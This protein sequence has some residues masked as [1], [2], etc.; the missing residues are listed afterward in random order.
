MDF[1]FNPG[2]IA[3]L[4]ATAN[5]K[6]GG[7]SILKNLMTGFSGNIYPVNPRYTEINSLPCYENITQVPD[8]VDMA[9]I[10]VPATAAPE[11]V[12]GCA[13]RGIPGVIIQSAGFSETG[14]KGKALQNQLAGISRRTGIRIWGPNCMGL[15][16]AIHKK[17]FSFVSP[18][19]WDA[20]LLPGGI[21]LIVQSG[22]LSAGFLMDTMTRDKMGVSKV[23]SIGNKVDVNECDVLE[24]LLEDRDTAVIGL[25]LESIMD[26]RR[27]F[28]TCRDA[29]KPIV[30]LQ[31]GKSENGARA[32][33]SHTASMAGNSAII[34]GAMTQAGVV[35][36]DDFKQMMDLSHTLSLYPN[37][38]GRG[39]GRIAI[40]TFSG[41]AGIVSSDFLDRHGLALAALSTDTHQSL[42]AVFPQWMPPS[43]PIDLW[44]AIE[45]SG[46]DKAYGQ[47]VDAVCADPGVDAVFLHAFVGGPVWRL[48]LAP[49][50]E[51]A[52]KAGKPIFFWMIGNEKDAQQVQEEAHHLK[53]P[54]F[55]EVARAVECMAAVFS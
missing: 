20:G 16:D 4:G 37:T 3:L 34:K 55:R 12:Q 40:A 11:V 19:I 22:M 38:S 8:P 1:F 52:R 39:P 5:E 36:A 29:H 49:I 17:V 13:D 32:A 44:P 10:F 31:G 7:F 53:F 6:K 30:V 14:E 27:F 50:V 47:T 18:G 15:V 42:K 35:Q 41:G 28:E 51:T 46:V 24:Y 26:G 2:G 48:K 33:M 25:Y 9:I 23:C 54:V 43:N 45:R 21:S